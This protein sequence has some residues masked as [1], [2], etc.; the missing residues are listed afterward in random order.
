MSV[1]PGKGDVRLSCSAF[2]YSTFYND[3]YMGQVIDSKG[4]LV[5]ASKG[6]ARLLES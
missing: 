4:K 6:R 2:I 1:A 3:S 5:C